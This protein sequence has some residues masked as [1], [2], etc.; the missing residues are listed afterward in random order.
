[1]LSTIFWIYQCESHMKLSKNN[2][3]TTLVGNSNLESQCSNYIAPLLI[4]WAGINPDGKY[5][6][7]YGLITEQNTLSL[8]INI[9]CVLE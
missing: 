5:L 3:Q 7:I 9:P 1:M 6:I 4:T 8:Y 2:A